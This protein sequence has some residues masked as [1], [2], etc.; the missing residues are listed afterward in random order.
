MEP[1]F[2]QFSGGIPEHY[3]RGLGPHIFMDFGRDLAQRAAATKP[4]RL[5]EIAAGTGIVTRM[6]RDA[7]PD[8]THITATDLNPPMLDIARRKFQQTENIEFQP[9]DAMA[10]PFEEAAFDTVVCQFGVMFFPDKDQSYREVRRVL[11]SGGHYLFNVWDSFEY[12]PNARIQHETIAS[13]FPENPPSFYKLPFSYYRSDPIKAS[14]IKAGFG[15]ISAAVLRIEKEIQDVESFAHGVVYGNPVI[16]EIR[17]RGDIDPATVVT[18]VAAALRREFGDDP[19]RMP[20]QAI[21]WSATK[22]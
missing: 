10:L 20:L 6:L 5:L 18:A 7:L 3:D 9:V 22:P 14:L 19:A 16:D 15:H 4:H 17:G 12:N 13:F 1:K 2:A 8:A 11:V 21:A